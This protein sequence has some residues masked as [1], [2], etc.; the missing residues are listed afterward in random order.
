MS[1]L[2]EEKGLKKSFCVLLVSFNT[3]ENLHTFLK[4][5]QCIFF[6]FF[7]FLMLSN[8]APGAEKAKSERDDKGLFV[9]LKSFFTVAKA[10]A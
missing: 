10:T 3:V 9:H 7:K 4:Q 6:F 8:T 2:Q 1:K 5:G